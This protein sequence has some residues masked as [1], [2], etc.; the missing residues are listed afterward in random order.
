M[1]LPN[2]CPILVSSIQLGSLGNLET[3]WWECSCRI[4]P[5]GGGGGGG[6]VSVGGVGGAGGNGGNGRVVI[7]CSN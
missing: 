6:A 3:R 4:A 7:S 5:G 1:L 2:G